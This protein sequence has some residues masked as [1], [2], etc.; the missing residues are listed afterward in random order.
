MTVIEEIE[1]L[2]PADLHYITL[3]HKFTWLNILRSLVNPHLTTRVESH[4]D[5]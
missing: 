4:V 1:D 3:L 2:R 5:S